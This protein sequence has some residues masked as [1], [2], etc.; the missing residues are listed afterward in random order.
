VWRE[1]F[2]WTAPG[3]FASA[4]AAVGVQVLYRYMGPL[5]L[6]C[7]PPIWVVYYSY[8]LY[9]ERIHLFTAKVQQDMAHIQEL[10]ELNQA[11]IASLATAIDAKDRYTGSATPAASR[12]RTSRS[13]GASSRWST[14]ST[15]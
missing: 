12:A 1:N 8:R 6:I 4:S 9:M 2:L 13:A 10:N 15:R 3:F 5:S 14:C 11:V 7:L